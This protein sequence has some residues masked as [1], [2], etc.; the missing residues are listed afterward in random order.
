MYIYIYIHI[1]ITLTTVDGRN[2]TPVD[3]YPL[4][5]QYQLV[6]DVFINSI[7]VVSEG[8]PPVGCSLEIE[9][10]CINMSMLVD[11]RSIRFTILHIVSHYCLEPPII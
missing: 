10:G 8:I 5:V 9:S 1:Q 6:Q 3:K 4:N 11:I 7:I 2:P